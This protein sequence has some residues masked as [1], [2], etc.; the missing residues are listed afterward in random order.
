[1][2]YIYVIHVRGLNKTVNK[3]KHC[4]NKNIQETPVNESNA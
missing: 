3:K 1:M 4:S 2:Y